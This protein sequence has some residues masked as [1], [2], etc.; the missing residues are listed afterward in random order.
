MWSRRAVLKSVA[1]AAGAAAFGRGSAAREP[2]MVRS[3]TPVNF[4][5]PA[6]ACDC[7]NP[8]HWRRDPVS[9]LAFAQLHTRLGLG[10]GAAGAAPVPPHR[11][12]RHRAAE[13]V[14]DR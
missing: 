6:G 5:V 4:D 8:R 13:R 7:H 11:Q 12:S 9:I 10:R 2:G 14:W 1:A 3:V